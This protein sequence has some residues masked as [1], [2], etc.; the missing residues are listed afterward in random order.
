METINVKELLGNF[1]MLANNFP[2]NLNPKMQIVCN[3]QP[4]YMAD[5]LLFLSEEILS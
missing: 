4:E 1:E 3:E 2:D 5:E